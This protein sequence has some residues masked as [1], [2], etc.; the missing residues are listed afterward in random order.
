[1][2]QQHQ[3]HLRTHKRCRIPPQTSKVR[4]QK[5]KIPSDSHAREILRGPVLGNSIVYKADSLLNLSES[6]KQMLP[7]LPTS[8]HT[9]SPRLVNVRGVASLL[10]RCYQGHKGASAWVRAQQEDLDASGG[11]DENLPSAELPLLSRAARGQRWSLG[12][13]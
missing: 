1:M 11:R 2:D 13:L 9:L 4:I 3:P 7:Q 5:D 6:M 12:C 8:H 10:G